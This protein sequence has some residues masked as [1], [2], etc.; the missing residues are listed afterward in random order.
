MPSPFPGMD[1]YLEDPRVWPDFH[2]RLATEISNILN[3]SLPAPYYSP[4]GVWSEVG[5]AEGEALG[6]IVPDV[7][8]ARR[9]GGTVG[10]GGVA[11]L[12]QARGDVAQ[13]YEVD[14]LT[15]AIRHRVV[16]IRDSSRG[17]S[18]VTLI[19]I[20][21]PSNKRPGRDREAYE[22]KRQEVLD[23]DA[24]LIE[25]DL[26]RGGARVLPEPRLD[27]FVGRIDPPPDYLVLVN[28]A[29]RRRAASMGVS[30]FPVGLREWL[31]CIPVPLREGMPEV[32]LDLQFVVNRTYDHGPYRRSL[33]YDQPPSPP[34]AGADAEWAAARVREAWGGR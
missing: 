13:A 19:E 24:S 10:H 7:A 21:S 8:V 20:L 15:E 23:S 2:D 28:R 14:V 5:I 17:H 18:L 30:V 1:P 31:P 16:E 4:L 11:V 22:R 29:W 26:L 3:A 33:D 12:E 27:D 32:P 6:W 34:L 9:P 25:L